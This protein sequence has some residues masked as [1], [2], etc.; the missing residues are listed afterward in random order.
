M[1]GS[2][3]GSG[4]IVPRTVIIITKEEGRHDPQ[5]KKT[6]IIKPN[7][8]KKQTLRTTHYQQKKNMINT[9]RVLNRIPYTFY[10]VVKLI[11]PS[12]NVKKLK[13]IKK[14]EKENMYQNV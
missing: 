10:V 5:G 6:N 2:G 3:S 1:S 13:M 11:S 14:K 9:T 7:K 8:N 12:S 4:S